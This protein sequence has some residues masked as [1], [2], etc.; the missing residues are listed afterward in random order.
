MTQKFPVNSISI[1]TVTFGCRVG[2]ELHYNWLLKKN[3]SLSLNLGKLQELLNGE[4]GI[5]SRPEVILPESTVLPP[6]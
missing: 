5:S 3:Y 4:A 6:V 1:S 2:C